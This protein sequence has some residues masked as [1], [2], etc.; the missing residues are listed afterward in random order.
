[1]TWWIPHS[2]S[3]WTAGLRNLI[4]RKSI[5]GGT[6]DVELYRED[7]SISIGEMTV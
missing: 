1:M 4:V 3:H 7:I 2:N 5:L 6:V